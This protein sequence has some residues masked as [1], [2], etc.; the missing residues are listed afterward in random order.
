MQRLCQ[1]SARSLPSSIK[2]GGNQS[3][4]FS[5]LSSN[6]THRPQFRTK[7][8]PHQVQA[9]LVAAAAASTSSAASSTAFATAFHVQATEATTDGDDDDDDNDAHDDMPIP[10]DNDD[11]V[12]VSTINPQG[13][14]KTLTMNDIP[15][16]PAIDQGPSSKQAQPTDS[17]KNFRKHCSSSSFDG[18]YN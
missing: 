4:S 9:S 6:Q 16:A 13:A 8:A 7:N 18:S 11:T 2:E 14:N 17:K 3:S 5:F 10:F 15:T 12:N 1:L